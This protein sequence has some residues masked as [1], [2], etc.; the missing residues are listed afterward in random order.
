MKKYICEHAGCNK[1]ATKKL[2]NGHRVCE[3]CAKEFR[4]KGSK[5]FFKEVLV[6]V[7]P[8]RGK[9]YALVEVKVK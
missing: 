2:K 6:E 7:I 1:T 8:P 4:R 9:I 5:M 3:D